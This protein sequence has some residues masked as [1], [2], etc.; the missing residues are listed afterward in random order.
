MHDEIQTVAT[1]GPLVVLCWRGQ[2]DAQ[3]SQ[4]QH[5]LI[6]EIARSKE[7]LAMVVLLEPNASPPDGA[8]RE[9]LRKSMLISPQKTV[10]AAYVIRD[11][12]FGGAIKRGVITGL[13]LMAKQP[14]PVRTFQT[15]G[16]ALLW[17]ESL[18]RSRNTALGQVTALEFLKQVRARPSA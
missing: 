4:R 8:S 2:A 7:V 16:E 14:Y 18:L 5:D 9:I 10:A 15:D 13:S 3:R 6:V 11:E 17:L 12:G 1:F